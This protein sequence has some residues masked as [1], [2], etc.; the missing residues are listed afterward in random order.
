MFIIYAV[1][2]LKIPL[3]GG[4][5]L[6]VTFITIIFSIFLNEFVAKKI[7]KIRQ[8]RVKTVTNKI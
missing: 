3:V 8:L 6:V 5:G 2:Y 7:E 1:M 4:Q